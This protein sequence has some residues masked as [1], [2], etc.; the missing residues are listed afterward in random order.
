[1]AD[2]FEFA[3]ACSVQG[4]DLD[5]PYANKQYNYINDINGGVY[6]GNGLTLVQFDLSSI[7]NSQTLVDPSQMFFAIPITYVGAY[8]AT[9]T[10]GAP[11]A[12]TTVIGQWASLGL[13]SGFIQLV[14]G[15]DLQ[16][17]GKIIE[18]FQPNLNAYVSFKMFSNASKDDQTSLFPSLGFGTIIDNPESLRY[19]NTASA[20][21]AGA[22]GTAGAPGGYG[23]SGGNGITN[24][25]PFAANGNFGDQV[26]FGAQNQGTYN[27]G[28]YSRLNRVTD[29]S[30]TS[31]TGS[32][33]LY[34]SP[35]AGTPICSANNLTNEFR[36]TYQFSNNYLIYNDV[37]IVRA[38]DIF[39][40]MKQMPL[41]KKW[42]GIVR[43]YVNTGSLGVVLNP[44][45]TTGLMMTSAS[46]STF[47][48]TCPLM[49]SSTLPASGQGAFVAG[50][51]VA[52]AT[53]TSV[54]GINLAN[55]GAAN[56]MTACRCYY[57]QVTLKAM[58]MERYI[59]E[60]RSK[61]VCWKSILFNQANG[62]TAGSTY[63][64]LLQ[65]GVSNIASVLII[66][67]LSG[68]VN[69]LLNIGAAPVTG[70]TPFSQLLSPF[71]T[72]PATTSPVSLT[73][74]QVSVGGVNQLQGSPLFYSFENF[75]E[76]YSS[77]DKAF[78]ATD[79]GLNC[80]LISQYYWEQS[81][82]YY[83]DCSRGQNADLMT[84][85]NVNVSF[86][87][88]SAVTMDALFYIVYNDSCIIDVETGLV[89]G[90]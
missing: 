25:Q 6:G 44:A 78:S 41:T 2:S 34:V 17:N 57:P 13:K 22:F 33:G 47:T 8:S 68:T 85:R 87:N 88:N 50:L 28:Y 51:F 80:G 43:L 52:R 24:C 72:C 42:D 7:Y 5:T 71:D 36:A 1:M 70:I 46:V 63:S 12:P 84:P 18:Q 15:A 38:C 65:S 56:P 86:T 39:D 90:R 61:K 35:N 49:V 20:T 37:A 23:P 75:L 54:F 48:N 64:A 16:V 69:G 73:N 29:I 66:P 10:S 26:A 60:N 59:S 9:T 14:H 62:I 77:S 4:L 74:L 83:V 55:S 27:N 19:S 89:S 82:W 40:S 79:L 58:Q 21:T 3:R 81:R 31:A 67:L 30:A 45:G 53:Q 32:N 11:V 76:Q